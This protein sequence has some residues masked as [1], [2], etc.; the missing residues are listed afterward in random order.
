MA[1]K[2]QLRAH[3][4]QPTHAEGFKTTGLSRPAMK[5]PVGQIE[6]HAPHPTHFLFSIFG[7]IKIILWE[8]I[9]K[10]LRKLL[11]G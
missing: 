5:T 3:I 4:L 2:G 9:N 11:V 6:M 10:S 1:L 8:A 7:C